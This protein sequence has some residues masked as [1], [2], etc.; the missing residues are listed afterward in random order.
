MKNSFCGAVATALLTVVMNV[1]TTHAPI[2]PHIL[3]PISRSKHG[4]KICFPD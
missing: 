3:I 1:Q 2:L 4:W